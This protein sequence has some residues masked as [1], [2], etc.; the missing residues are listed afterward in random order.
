M[1]FIFLFLHTAAVHAGIGLEPLNNFLAGMNMHP[2][3]NSLWT[4]QLKERGPS[5]EAVVQ[6]SVNAALEEERATVSEGEDEGM[7]ISV[8]GAWQSRGSG[9][10]YNSASGEYW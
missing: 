3:S 1:T 9:R 5:L 8:D 6:E 2:I 4:A 10:S 7:T